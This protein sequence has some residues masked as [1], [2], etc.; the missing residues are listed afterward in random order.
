MTSNSSPWAGLEVGNV[1]TR[2]VSANA[3]WNWFWAVMPKADVA[4]I[5]KLDQMPELAC[6]LPRLRDLEVGFQTLPAGTI[7]YVRLKARSQIELFETLC[8][9]IVAA[10]ELASSEVEALDRAI[11]RMFRWHHLLRAGTLD[12]LS[13]EEQKGLIG[14][15]EIF[16][17]LVESMGAKR[18]LCAWTG[19]SG[20][21]KDFEFGSGCIEVKARRGAAQPFV[22]ISNEFQLADVPG[23]SL[24]LAVLAVDRVHPPHGRSLGEIVA[25]MARR[26]EELDPSTLVGWE[27]RLAEAGYDTLQDYSEWRWVVSSRD[28]YRVTNGFPRIAVP[29]VPVGVTS[30]A[31]SISLSA[32]APFRTEWKDVVAQL[33]E[34]VT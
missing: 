12:V 21:P 26:L 23:Q 14:E 15:I 11:R 1:D 28:Y 4:L 19:P 5:L 6:D 2:R 18:A 29:A 20:A 22:K 27:R 16:R 24:W 13:E 31:Y 3:R 9:D 32:C 30:L 33:A 17:H 8:R 7:L 10:S 34:D 25:S